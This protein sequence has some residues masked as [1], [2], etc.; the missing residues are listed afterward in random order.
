MTSKLEA[1][2]ESLSIKVH[3]QTGLNLFKEIPLSEIRSMSSDVDNEDSLRVRI[4]DACNIFDRINKK[5]I[6][7][8]LSVSSKGSK[9]TFI[10][11]MKHICK[12]DHVLI[13]QEIEKPLGMIFLLR[14]YLVHRRNSNIKKG[15]DYFQLSLPLSDFQGIWNKVIAILCQLLELAD[16]AI[17]RA[18]N[19]IKLKQDEIDTDLQ[20]VLAR[21]MLKKYQY[22]LDGNKSKPIILQLISS[23]HLSDT[24]LATQFNLDVLK[25]RELLLDLVPHI[26]SIK[27]RDMESTELKIDDHVVPILKNH[28]FGIDS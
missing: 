11:L 1:L 17:Q 14:G 21:R 8:Y 2:F 20:E 13:S 24:E 27:H 23:G 15:L 12:N 4:T 6:D 18:R 16:N 19:D 5:N 25:L 10:N 22:I 9:T 7:Q 26:I 28:Y 3:E